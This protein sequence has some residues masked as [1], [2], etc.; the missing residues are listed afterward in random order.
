MKRYLLGDI[1]GTNAR[2][3]LAEEGADDQPLVFRHKASFATADYRSLEDALSR[4]LSDIQRP[5]LDAAAICAAGPLL[6]EGG[7]DR[8][9]MTNCPWDISSGAIAQVTGCAHPRLM[10]DFTA[11]ALAIP[12]LPAEALHAVGDGVAEVGRPIALL[13]AGTGL[14]VASLVHDGTRYIPVPGEGGHVDLPVTD[15]FEI[16][17]LRRFMARFGRV[18]VERVLSG[19]GLV[20]LYE[21]LGELRRRPVEVGLTPE[22]VA[23][24]A[25]DGSCPIAVEAVSFFCGWLGSVAGNLALTLWASGGIY[26][27]GGIV[28]GWVV[29]RSGLFD[30]AHF[31]RRFEAKGRFAEH[32]AGFPVHVILAEEPA[33]FG[34]AAAA[35]EASR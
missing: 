35:R 10:N 15:E 31:R 19:P 5:P 12:E 34:L 7:T 28:P 6:S 14:G 17:I 26:I 11:L 16:E 24:H 13:G 1:G 27:G 21:V 8:I 20:S 32:L 2:F 25:G 23:A 22:E 18:S 33:F 29:S 9:R 3:A 30:E 4:F